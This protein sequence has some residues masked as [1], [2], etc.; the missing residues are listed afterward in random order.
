MSN[1]KLWQKRPNDGQPKSSK[2]I[3]FAEEETITGSSPSICENASESSFHEASEMSST[4][5]FAILTEEVKAEVDIIAPKLERETSNKLREAMP[6]GTLRFDRNKL[7]GRDEHTAKLRDALLRVKLNRQKRKTDVGATTEFVLIGGPSGCGK[8]AL[9]TSIEDDVERSATGIYLQGQFEQTAGEEPYKALAISFQDLCWRAEDILGPEGFRLFQAET[10]K[11]LDALELRFLHG[12]IP[13]MD[14]I[15]PLP[16]SATNT[17]YE[18]FMKSKDQKNRL[19]YGFIKF[20]RVACAAFSPLVIFLDDLQ[21]ADVSSLDLLKVLISD[22][23]GTNLMVIGCYRSDEINQSLSNMIRD[24]RRPNKAPSK[25][26]LLS[27]EGSKKKLLLASMASTGS[28]GGRSGILLPNDP[29]TSRLM[30]PSQAFGTSLVL[31]DLTLGN[32]SVDDVITIIMDL[33]ALED[34]HV[35]AP[36]AQILQRRT[37]GNPNYLK[38]LITVLYED[39]LL[40][41]N[42]GTMHWSW[43]LLEIEKSSFA[44]DNVVDLTRRGIERNSSKDLRHLLLCVACLGS[45]CE[46]KYIRLVWK[47]SNVGQTSERVLQQ[48]LSQAVEQMFLERIGQSQYRYS[49]DA[50][51]EA[52]ISLI[53]RSE[54]DTLLQQVGGILF[55]ELAEEELETML[56][57]VADLLHNSEWTDNKLSQ[58]LLRAAQKAKGVSAFSS[59]SFY[60]L[61]GI[62]RLPNL[63]G[64]E[65]E[66]VQLAVKLYSIAAEAERSLGNLPQAKLLCEAVIGHTHFPLFDKLKAHKILIELFVHE[67]D[68]FDLSLNYSLDLLDETIG[69]HF[70]RSKAGQ[71]LGALRAI[72]QMKLQQ[73]I[74][75]AYKIKDLSMMTDPTRLFGIELM[76]AATFSAFYCGKPILMLIVLNKRIQWSLKYGFHPSMAAAFATMA[77]VFMHVLGDWERGR[78]MATAA[79]Q[80]V[81]KAKSCG[82]PSNAEEEILVRLHFLVDPWTNPAR[83]LSNY[84]IDGYKICMNQGDVDSAFKIIISYVFNHL[85]SGKE[86]N[87]LEGDVQ[88]YQPQMAALKY[89]QWEY[90]LDLVGQASLNLMG[91]S[92]HTIS[93][94]GKIVDESSGVMTQYRHTHFAIR[95]LCAHFGEYK[96]GAQNAIKIGYDW[97]KKYPGVYFGYDAFHKAICLYGEARNIAQLQGNSCTASPSLSKPTSSLYKKH[98][99]KYHA[100]IDSWVKHGAPNH[101]HHLSVLNAEKIALLS[102]SQ[103]VEPKEVC[104]LYEKAIRD[105]VRGGFVNHAALAEER[106][107]DYLFGI[108]NKAEGIY[109]LQNAIGRFSDW[110]ATRRVEQLRVKLAELAGGVT[111]QD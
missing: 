15:A 105:S 3:S 45:I 25:S 94:S 24:L 77:G 92:E 17:D 43:D 11:N 78:R 84:F 70:P 67:Q 59:A 51:K 86:L 47:K 83:S 71:A 88:C 73:S 20:I 95:F 106:Y 48:L 18:E 80:L 65:D 100:M 42:Y 68:D 5:R 62:K 93:F 8:T 16:E 98:A 50:V 109:H 32:L 37:L 97:E 10:T 35:A 110:G 12:I 34:E 4:S 31:T 103:F 61:H 101:V 69:C 44:T 1:R 26:R 108:D 9:A 81:Q 28:K 40:S 29:S 58:L 56:F 76:Q 107:S 38:T 63:G 46:E 2:S 14:H 91:K 19:H 41:F 60:A 96:A 36:L 87:D 104:Q 85:L 99:E 6:L 72:K 55:E 64:D 90:L 102:C 89:D 21:W 79:H 74:P 33:L 39:N 75:S 111:F 52:A 49:H 54:F 30:L 57:L 23:V 53:P 82:V 66:N 7:Y 27:R 22:Q 13:S